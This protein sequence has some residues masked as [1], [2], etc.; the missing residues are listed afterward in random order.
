MTSDFS[1]TAWALSI[2]KMT[3]GTNHS[4]THKY[5]I[6]GSAASNSIT[7]R[8]ISIQGRRVVDEGKSEC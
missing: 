3:D 1:V 8:A 5:R 6:A 7:E 2:R 4:P